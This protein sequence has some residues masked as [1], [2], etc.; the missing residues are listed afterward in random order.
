MLSL[1]DMNEMIKDLDGR[2]LPFGWAKLLW[3]LRN[4]KTHS[5]RVAL[6]GVLKSLQATRMASQLAFMMIEHSR[7]DS[8]KRFGAARGEIGWILEDN[9]PMRSIADAIDSNVNR[10]YR[11]YEKAL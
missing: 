10:V 6:M 1:P 3:R 4:P 11:I 7:R 9:A 2:L 5:M 8:A